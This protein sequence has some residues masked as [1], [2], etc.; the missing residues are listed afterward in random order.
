MTQL[1]LMRTDPGDTERASGSVCTVCSDPDRSDRLIINDTG[2]LCKC[3][4][5]TLN[6]QNFSMDNLGLKMHKCTDPG[7][8]HERQKG[9]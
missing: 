4:N 8:C 3:A 7:V 5:F 9:R 1:R 2:L 6:I